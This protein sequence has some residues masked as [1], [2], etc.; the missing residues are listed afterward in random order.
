[1]WRPLEK[2][3]AT[4]TQEVKLL[5]SSYLIHLVKLDLLVKLVSS[6]EVCYYPIQASAICRYP[7][8]RN[9]F[10][11]RSGK[12]LDMRFIERSIDHNLHDFSA[13]PC[14]FKYNVNDTVERVSRFLMVRRIHIAILSYAIAIRVHP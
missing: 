11:E 14:V 1:M 3:F 6:R 7:Y 10:S 13:M 12:V 2:S 8:G 9:I 5:D 4:R